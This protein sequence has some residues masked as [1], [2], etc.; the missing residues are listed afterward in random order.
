MKSLLASLVC[1]CSFY[2]SAQT[3]YPIGT[4]VDHLPYRGARLVE[5]SDDRVFCATDVSL[6]SVDKTYLSEDKISKCTGLSDIGFSAMRYDNARHQLV[7]AYNN[8]NVDLWTPDKVINVPDIKRK[9]IV[10][11]KNIYSVDVNDNLAYLSCGFGIVAMDLDKKEIKETYYI[12]PNGDALKVNQTAVAFGKIFA[13]TDDGLYVAD[14]ASPALNNYDVWERWDTVYHLPHINAQHVLSTPNGLYATFYNEVYRYDGSVWDTV[15]LHPGFAIN[16]MRYFNGQ[17]Y[18]CEH[19]G[20]TGEGQ[21]TVINDND[22]VNNVIWS[23]GYFD[24][25]SDVQVESSG[26]M[27]LADYSKGMSVRQNGS[28]QTLYPNGP[29]SNNAWR[30]EANNG[31][32]YVAAGSVISPGIAYNGDGFFVYENDEWKAYNGTTNPLLSDSLLD[33]SSITHNDITGKTYSGSNDGASGGGGLVERDNDQITVYKQGFLLNQPA[34]ASNFPAYDVVTDHAGNVWVS[35]PGTV[36]PLHVFTAAREWLSFQLQ[37]LSSTDGVQDVYPD[38]Y[39]QVWII[40]KDEGLEVYGYGSDLASQADDRYRRFTT[41]VGTGNLPSNTVLDMVIDKSD[42]AWLGTDKGIAVIYCVGGATEEGCDAQQIIVSG[43]DSIAGY[44]LETE[45]INAIAVDAGNRKWVGTE[46][47]V[48]LLSADGLTEVHHF[49]VDNSP[50]FSN[51]ILDIDVDD[52]TGLVYIA[53]AEGLLAYQSDATNPWNGGKRCEATVFP[54]PVHHDYSGP[55][56][57]RNVP[58]NATVKITDA[59]GGLVYQTTASGG[60]AVWN[61]YD[62]NGR[63][64]SSGVY[65]VTSVSSDGALTC[66]AKLVFIN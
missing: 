12:G 49:T 59:A 2:A 38:N 9:N 55:I 47:G 27:W 50:L 16:A 60:T 28:T 66:R 35:N 43:T 30:V 62:Y 14:A 3:T 40:L 23:D 19:N 8:S 58:Y 10:G 4:W 18:L 6:Y 56:A 37:N 17:L 64:A 24:N 57:I 7:I 11:D 32:A 61:G 54:N 31:N 13:A 20:G 39:S 63:K 46:N 41:G 22:T 51:S 34:F 42:E 52:A 15:R 26:R 25:P 44:L 48:W 36:K 45:R 65:Y 21:I 29:Y 53:T 33:F 5:Q 1:F